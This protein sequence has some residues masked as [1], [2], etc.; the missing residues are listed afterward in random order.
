MPATDEAWAAFV[1]RYQVGAVV[2]GDVVSVVPF[3]AF[4][5]IGE[6]DGFAPVREWPTPLE[7]GAVV[8]VRIAAIDADTRRFAVHPA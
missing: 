7:E 1:A 5:R 4:V 2:H 3:G 8:P 6:V